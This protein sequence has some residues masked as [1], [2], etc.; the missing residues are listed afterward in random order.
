MSFASAEFGDK[1]RLRALLDHFS[2]SEDP[3]ET[4]R[5]AHPLPEVLLLLVCGTMA[6]CDDFDAIA[7]WGEAHLAFLRRYLPYHHGAPGGRWLNLLTNRINPALFSAAFIAW[8]RETWPQAP[9]LIAIDGKTS[10]RSHDR[11]F[12]KGPLH[13]VSA[14]A[15]A[16]RL[17][18][19]QEAV[20]GKS[21][22]LSAIPVLLERRPERRAG[23]NRRH[24]HQRENRPGDPGRGRR[25][26]VGGEGQSADPAPSFLMKMASTI[27]R[28]LTTGSCSVSRAQ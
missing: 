27:P 22:E 7:D 4:W 12:D 13:L 18:L 5:V 17:V 25:L 14:C 28:V 24:R 23:L 26:S 19:G 1:S 2:V 11:R 20:E 15:S 10:R 3:R 9:D 21:N 8:V 6:D 16:S